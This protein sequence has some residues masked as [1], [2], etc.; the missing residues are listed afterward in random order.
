MY[1]IDALATDRRG[2][3]RL[4]S[5][6]GAGVG[7]L[8]TATGRTVLVETASRPVWAFH[9]DYL[10]L[11]TSGSAEPYRPPEGARGAAHVAELDADQLARIHYPA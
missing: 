11:D 10:Y 5:A 4:V 9:P 6:M 2:F 7:L 1:M 3:F 8:G